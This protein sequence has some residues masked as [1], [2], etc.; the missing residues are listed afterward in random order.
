MARRY[1]KRPRRRPG[2]R[3]P[4]RP[5]AGAFTSNPRPQGFTEPGMRQLFD[6]VL[7][8]QGKERRQ[9]FNQ[10]STGLVVGLGLGGA[11]LGYSWA[12]IAGAVLGLG[13]GATVGGTFVERQRFYRR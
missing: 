3:P 10:A 1:P 7:P 9:F 11:M 4:H 12:G 2:R 8:M 5:T 6:A 13:A